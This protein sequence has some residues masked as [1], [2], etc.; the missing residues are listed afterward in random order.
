LSL[1]LFA[2]IGFGPAAQPN[3]QTDGNSLAAQFGQLPISFEV[4]QGQTDSRVQFLARGSG[5]NLFL[6]SQ[7]AVLRLIHR[8]NDCTPQAQ[9][10]KL[11]ETPCQEKSHA[12]VLRMQLVGPTGTVTFFD[13]TSQTV[14]GVVPLSN[15]MASLTTTLPAYHMQYIQAT[16]NGDGSYASSKSNV[17]T[18]SMQ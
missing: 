8:D 2:S 10:Q 11:G 3:R 4:N 1:L 13:L 17:I 16:Y 5:Y 14:M 6:T 12:A 9:H 18:E 7:E 15:G